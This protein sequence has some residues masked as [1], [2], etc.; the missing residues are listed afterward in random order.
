MKKII[1]VL[2]IV[3]LIFIIKT[4]KEEQI[5]IPDN[6]IRF[7]IIANSNSIADQTAK[8]QVVKE[9]YPELI[10]TT[11]NVSDINEARQNIQDSQ[12]T[13][14]PIIEKYTKDYQINYGN[15]Y[16]PTKEFKGVT[17]ESGNYE[18][19]VISL[20]EAKGDNWW[21]VLFPPLCLLDAP[22]SQTDDV[23]YQ[24]YTKKILEKYMQ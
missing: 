23:T 4:P 21:C 9:L 13:I 6:A 24:L 8:M 7:R 10:K 11:Q 12:S 20:G 5:I 2:A 1:I 14:T 22:E 18:S 3:M 16:F 15:N 19:L 17:Y